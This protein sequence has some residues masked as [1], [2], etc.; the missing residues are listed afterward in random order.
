MPERLNIKLTKLQLAFLELNCRYP[1]LIGGYGSGKTYTLCTIALL[2]AM[3]SPHAVIAIYE[4]SY[5]LVKRVLVP[6]MTKLFYNL[7]ITYDYHKTDF[8]WTPHIPHCG[9]ISF[10]TMENPD[11]IVGDESYRS[12]VDE[13]DTLKP[14]VAKLAWEKILGR[15]R[16]W[17][18]DLPEDVMVWNNKNRRY[19]PDNKVR[20]YTT[21]EGYRFCY[22]RWKKT[23]DREYRYIQVPS[24]SNP[25]LP[26]GYI[27][28]LYSTYSKEL[29]EAYVEGKF[30]NLESG[31]VYH[32]FKR[33]VHHS[34][35]VVKP[36]DT[37]HIGMDFNIENMAAIVNVARGKAYVA[38]DEFI[39]SD[40][41]GKKK[42]HDT[43]E[44]SRLI[45]KRYPNH[46]IYI[47]PDAS[48]KGRTTA[49][50]GRASES[51]LAILKQSQYNFKIRKRESNP[52]VMDRVQAVNTAL[53]KLNL[54]VNTNTCKTL[55]ECLEQQTYDNGK[56]DKS[57][58][59]D[60]PNDAYGYFVYY[61]MPLRKPAFDLNI[62]NF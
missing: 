38:V 15:T 30:V 47:Y 1:A 8:V 16:Q 20:A 32:I 27:D 24:Y 42:I 62:S 29:V 61:L 28:S 46:T 51:D 45:R 3:H 18:R 19:E 39:Y 9:K 4:P 49:G 52:D 7:G 37:L 48:A 13:I 59:K 6:T 40:D 10:R 41:I 33:D 34:D 35:E 5:K 36:G 12:H 26:E 23:K 22:E 60:H 56:P 17:P 21:P 53:E 31:S 14:E 55:T 54:L 25:W 44:M 58:G 2:D 43:T 50:T 57:T 11:A